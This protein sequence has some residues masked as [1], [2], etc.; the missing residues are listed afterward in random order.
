MAPEG[1]WA[2][3]ADE[4]PPSARRFATDPETIR[5]WVENRGGAP[6]IVKAT[7]DGE[8]AG[9]PL[10]RVRLPND[11][12]DPSIEDVD[13]GTFFRELEEENLVFVFEDKSRE[14]ED[15]DLYEIVPRSDT[16]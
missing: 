6:A 9:G 2:R 7:E 10:L 15:S 8:R 13:W 5:R 11:P 1:H 14:G 16:K 3:E 12:A 4:V